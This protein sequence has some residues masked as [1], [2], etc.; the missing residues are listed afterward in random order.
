ME[1]KGYVDLKHIGEIG[2]EGDLDFYAKITAKGIDI[3][4]KGKLEEKSSHD[5]KGALTINKGILLKKLEELYN[6]KEVKEGFPSQQDCIDWCN[7]VAPL[8][9]FNQQ[10]YINFVQNAHKMNLS[11][12]SYTLEPA[13]NIMKSQVQMAIEELKIE[14]ENELSLGEEVETKGMYIDESRIKELESI[15]KS[16]F[17]LSKL[18]QILKELNKCYKNECYIAVITLTRA[19]I[20]HIPPIF[21]CNN[22][23]EVTNQYKGSKSFKESM[24]HLEKSSRKIADQYLHCQIRK[25]ET[26]PNKTQVNFSNDIDVLLSEI[27]RILK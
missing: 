1:N 4:E 7:K 8:L 27:V 12:S 23:D 6:L 15:S 19:L 13:F 14:I 20:D 18:T 3:I 16:R 17:D 25:S 22:F 24:L 2:R 26:L 10:Y 21:D 5:G 9:K 11:L